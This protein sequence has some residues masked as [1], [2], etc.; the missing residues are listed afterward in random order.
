MSEQLSWAQVI[1]TFITSLFA[2]LAILVTYRIHRDSGAKIT[3]QMNMLGYELVAGS[4]TITTI[5]DGGFHLPETRRPLI[6]LCQVKLQNTGRTSATVVEIALAF[7]GEGV[8][9][10]SYIPR[11]FNIKGRRNYRTTKKQVFR[12]D[13]YDQTSVVFDFWSLVDKLFLDNPRLTELRMFAVAQVA[14]QESPYDSKKHGYWKIHRNYISAVGN[15]D[16]RRPKDIIAMELARSFRK[17]RIVENLDDAVSSASIAAGPCYEP[18]E[19]IE[20][21]VPYVTD[22]FAP[23]FPPAAEV[24]VSNAARRAA[25]T[26]ER[27]GNA[28][29]PRPM[30]KNQESN[31]VVSSIRQG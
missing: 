4:S 25:A 24:R 29:H 28:V 3:V 1:A 30:P 16:T 11:V 20:A 5:T 10:S 7:E 21:L 2:F 18:N 17:L 19:L 12:I 27:L 23:A 26:I 31:G 15:M 8:T 22:I 14:G 9:G 6:E 13:A